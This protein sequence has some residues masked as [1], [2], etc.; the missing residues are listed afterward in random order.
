VSYDL[1]T[2]HD[3]LPTPCPCCGAKLDAATGGRLAPR[4]GDVTI[5]AYCAAPLVF[6]EGGLRAPTDAERER[7][8]VD[9]TV[10]DYIAALRHLIEGGTT[11]AGR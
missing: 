2:T 9:Q 7:M 11:D 1:G 4:P 8:L 5:C 10:V 6:T 3:Q